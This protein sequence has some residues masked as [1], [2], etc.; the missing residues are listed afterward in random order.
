MSEGLQRPAP[1]THSSQGRDEWGTGI[2]PQSHISQ[3]RDEWGTGLSSGTPRHHHPGL[4]AAVQSLLYVLVVALFVMTFTVQPIRIPSESMEPT[5]LVGDFL[6]MDKQIGGTHW[7][8]PVAEVQRGDVVVFHDPVDDPS[9]HLVKRVIG[10][11]GDRIHLRDGVVIRN[12]ERLQEPYAVYRESPED[13]FRDDFPDLH[14]MQARVNPAWWIRLRGMVR[15]GEITVPA[16]S[17]FVMGDN[18]N[19]S[20]DSRYWGFVPRDAI[21]GRPFLIYFSWRQPGM[22]EDIEAWGIHA[23]TKSGAMGFGRWDRTLKVVR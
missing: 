4:L 21:V 20:E 9:V 19:D 12:G 15:D 1:P 11:P 3:Q 5:L 16:G 18:R 7:L 17:Y 13:R 23:E 14:T 8:L 22:D 6:M 2:A 10:V